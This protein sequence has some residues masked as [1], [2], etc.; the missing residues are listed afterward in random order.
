MKRI[1][2][3]ICLVLIVCGCLAQSSLPQADSL[4]AV[5]KAHPREDSIRVQLLIGLIRSVIYNS[6]DSAMK[7]SNEVLRISGKI[8]LESG[9]AFGYR[10]KG[11]FIIS[12]AIISRRW[13]TCNKR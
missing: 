1:F 5:M 2:L 4:T 10:Y 12:P 13:I 8:G 3:P 7:Y 11:W 6:P 9:I